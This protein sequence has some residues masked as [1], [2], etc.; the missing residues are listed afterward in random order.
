MS[1]QSGEQGLGG[2]GAESLVPCEADA[3]AEVLSRSARLGQ[4]EEGMTY[5]QM[6]W[7]QFRRQR[8]NRWAMWIIVSIVLLAA[9][10]DLIASEKP[11][12]AHFENK[13]YVLPNLFD[14]PELRIYDNTLLIRSMKKGDWAVL[15]MVPYGYN[16]HDL[17]HVLSGPSAEHWLGTD[18]GGRDVLSRIVHGSRVSLAVGIMAVAVLVLIG[19]A[20]GTLA[21]FYGGML[22]ILLMRILEVV[23]SVPTLLLLVAMLAVLAPQGWG[24]VLA[25][26]VVIGLIRWTDIARLI[27]GEILRV[28]TLDYVQASVAQGAS[29]LRIIVQH[30]LP[31]SISP[32]LVS[33]TFSMASAILLESALSFLGFG[34][35][36]DMASWGG[37]LNGARGDASAWWLAIFPG[38]AIF[39]TVTVYNIAGE[40][41]RD[42]ID[43]RLKT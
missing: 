16:S 15:P 43:P 3:A 33:A 27:R 10:A 31:N 17:R 14:P 26:M 29:D 2:S 34:I 13:T 19:I 21:G 24:A 20:F 35:P 30:I 11:L 42:A 5:S 23:H 40:G 41:L 4:R 7:R 37:L 6:V 12:L 1:P 36:D 38:F 39:L 25:M 28:K 18:Q 9:S 8:L 32:V 22:D